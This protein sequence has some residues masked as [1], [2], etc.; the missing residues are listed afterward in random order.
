[1]KMTY[2][3]YIL[4]EIRFILKE[5]KT[6]STTTKLNRGGIYIVEKNVIKR[7]RQYAMGKIAKPPGRNTI[8]KPKYK[9]NC[10]KRKQ[11]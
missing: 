9:I 11:E 5:K 7:E 6:Y 3:L 8:K 2:L 10:K 4:K 1:M